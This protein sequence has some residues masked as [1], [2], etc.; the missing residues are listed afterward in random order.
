MRHPHKV[1]ADEKRTTLSWGT[2][3]TGSM[4]DESDDTAWRVVVCCS[5]KIS[6]LSIDE[7]TDHECVRAPFNI[8]SSLNATCSSACLHQASDL[9]LNL[10]I[11]Q[12]WKMNKNIVS[13]RVKGVAYLLKIHSS[14]VRILPIISLS[15]IQDYSQRDGYKSGSSM[16]QG[17]LPYR[18]YTRGCVPAASLIIIGVCGLFFFMVGYALVRND[19][20]QSSTMTFS[21]RLANTCPTHPSCDQPVPSSLWFMMHQFPYILT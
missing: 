14:L 6:S 10:F 7:S 18:A 2:H 5:C 9:G 8:Y 4:V 13:D 17:P 20:L 1:V 21:R 12:S 11:R 19:L 3:K 15:A 16:W